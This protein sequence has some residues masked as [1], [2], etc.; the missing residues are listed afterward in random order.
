MRNRVT[1]TTLRRVQAL[2]QARSR[3]RPRA[4][5][6]PTMTLDEWEALAIAHQVELIRNNVS[7]IVSET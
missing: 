7:D 4:E 2:E 3:S 5:F 1:L 6:P